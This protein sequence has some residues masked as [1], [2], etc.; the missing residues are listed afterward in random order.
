MSEADEI[1]DLVECMV[2]A[3]GDEGRRRAVREI[4]G[5]IRKMVPPTWIGGDI[6]ADGSVAV[7]VSLLR[8]VDGHGAMLSSS[9]ETAKALAEARQDLEH[10]RAALAKAEASEASIRKRHADL[11]D[12]YN[13]ERARR[14]RVEQELARLNRAP[15]E[16]EFLRW[17]S[18]VEEDGTID[19][20]RPMAMIDLGDGEVLT[21]EIQITTDPKGDVEWMYEQMDPPEPDPEARPDY[22][23]DIPEPLPPMGQGCLERAIDALVD[24]LPPDIMDTKFNERCYRGDPCTVCQAEPTVRD[25]IS[26]TPAWGRC[27]G[28]CEEVCPKHQ[29]TAD[30]ATWCSYCAEATTDDAPP[31]T[32]AP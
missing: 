16:P 8:T 17:V 19:H 1:A 11:G 24:G 18:P 13:E 22:E 7:D 28:C 9:L 14:Q 30:G 26:N 2:H 6:P 3:F 23:P 10:L 12:L 4:A 5:R 31:H 15:R 20:S 27:E 21:V 25:I 29:H 32:E